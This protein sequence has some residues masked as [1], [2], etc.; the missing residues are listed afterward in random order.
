L[1]L[2][3]KKFELNQI[4]IPCNKTNT[5]TVGEILDLIPKKALDVVLAEQR[6]RGLRRPLDGVEMTNLAA[7]VMSGSNVDRVVP[8]EILIPIPENYTGIE[9]VKASEYILKFPTVESKF[10]RSNFRIIKRSKKVMNR[11]YNLH[12]V[13][14]IASPDR[15]HSSSEYPSNDNLHD[16]NDG[17]SPLSTIYDK[18]KFIYKNE[19][20]WNNCKRLYFRYRQ[21]LKRSPLINK[22]ATSL[23]IYYIFRKVVFSTISGSKLTH[24]LGCFEAFIFFSFLVWMQ[25]KDNK[26]VK[27]KLVYGQ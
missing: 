8:E 19:Y 16:M 9:C 13:D 26:K 12:K 23:I 4:S 18:K 20:S 3:T 25:K 22:V 2:K 27:R 1:E 24:L 17:S 7:C 15:S 14:E 5:I 21:K 11:N 10:E 6:Y